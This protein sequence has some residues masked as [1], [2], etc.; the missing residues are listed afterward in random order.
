M[1]ATIE[2]RMATYREA[3]RGAIMARGLPGEP[4]ADTADTVGGPYRLTPEWYE[5]KR[6][7]KHFDALVEALECW[8]DSRT[9]TVKAF[10]SKYGTNFKPDSIPE[11]TAFFD[12]K[13][14]AALDKAKS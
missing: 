9:I 1:T 8:R 5:L 3:Q 10:N 14:R 4:G 6:R 13:A 2:E 12:A 11:V 7:A